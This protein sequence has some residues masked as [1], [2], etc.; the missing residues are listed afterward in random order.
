MQEKAG[1]ACYF[2]PRPDNVVA[3]KDACENSHSLNE[4]F[5]RYDL[6]K[7]IVDP[8]II[9]NIPCNLAHDISK[10]L[11]RNLIFTKDAP[12]IDDEDAALACEVES[13]KSNPSLNNYC[14]YYS[15]RA[16]ALKAGG[17]VTSIARLDSDEEK[18][19]IVPCINEVYGIAP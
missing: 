11:H 19:A 2:V 4:T 17:V 10:E 5:Q 12:W 1:D 13:C 15:E 16:E 3:A 7:E 18:E 9:N 14:Q 8:E 6:C